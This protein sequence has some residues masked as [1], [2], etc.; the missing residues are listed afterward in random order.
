MFIS[1]LLHR[2]CLLVALASSSSLAPHVL[3]SAPAPADVSTASTASTASTVSGTATLSAAVA[4][5]WQ[6][7]P[8]ARA[9]EAQRHEV[10]AGTAAAQTLLAGSAVMGLAHRSDRGN[11]QAGKRESDLSLSAPIWLPGQQSARQVLAQASATGLEA[12]LAHAR[13]VLAGEVREKMWAVFVAREELIEVQ[14]HLK[15][16]DLLND[17]VMRRVNTGDLAR[18]DGMQAQQAVLA[19]R[20][21]VTRA[22]AS[23]NEALMRYR[24]LTG[25]HEIPPVVDETG[26]HTN[27]NASASASATLEAHPRMIMA[28]ALLQRAQAAL[29]V[30]AAS[31]RDPLSVGVSLRR[32]HDSSSAP[33]KHSVALSLQI[34]LGNNARNLVQSTAAQTG[35]ESASAELAQTRATLVA[36][37]DLA[38]LQL[39]SAREGL[40]AVTARTTLTREHSR[41]IE[42][43]FRLGERGLAE[44]LRA[45]AQAHDAHLLE[46]QQRVALGLAH[47]RLNQ[48]LGI[49]P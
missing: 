30:V 24:T 35:I 6:R 3:A 45:Q 18:T 27:A 22:K 42:N 12:Q 13:L 8:Q 39:A 16:L 28:Q 36:E 4:A 41:L 21:A 43:A 46:S 11:D 40:E 10:Q 25:L 14:D 7:S 26:D 37:I 2:A 20:A 29:G 5:A 9:L 48:A 38:R 33:A 1:N 15:H 44:V 49:L 19:A 23:Q 34:P 32:E 17:E 31:R 47:A